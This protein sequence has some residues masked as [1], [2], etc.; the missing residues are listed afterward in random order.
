MFSSFLL[1]ALSLIIALVYADASVEAY[2]KEVPLAPL[3]GY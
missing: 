1:L 3:V 2:Q